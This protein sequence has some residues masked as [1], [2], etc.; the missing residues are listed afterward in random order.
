MLFFLSLCSFLRIQPITGVWGGAPSGGSGAEPP[1]G[2]QGA[3]PPEAEKLFASG[4][5][6]PGREVFRQTSGREDQVQ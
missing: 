4:H 5:P 1:V 3:K 2:R 6:F